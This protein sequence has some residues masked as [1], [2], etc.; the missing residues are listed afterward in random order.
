[1]NIMRVIGGL[2]YNTETAEIL[3]TLPDGA[4]SVSDFRYESTSLYRTKNGRYFLAG[5][6]GALS[7][8]SENIPGSNS[9]RRGGEGIIPISED[10]ARD[11]LERCGDDGTAAIEKYFKI[12]DA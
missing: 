1:M 6:G 3:A 5:R 4:D 7:R 10:E 11:H 2:R 9:G 8:W 12:D